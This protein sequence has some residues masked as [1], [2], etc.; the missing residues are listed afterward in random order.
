MDAGVAGSLKTPATPYAPQVDGA[1]AASFFRKATSDPTRSSMPTTPGV[2]N[3]NQSGPL[4]P[5]AICWPPRRISLSC[6][7][8]TTKA[9]LKPKHASAPKSMESSGRHFAYMNA[10]VAPMIGT[11][12]T[13]KT[14][15]LSMGYLS[16]ILRCAPRRPHCWLTRMA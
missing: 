7:S 5:G 16:T 3:T 13:E 8:K 9:V 11:A 2:T 14:T 10:K 15:G 1:L 6:W 12:M 4:H